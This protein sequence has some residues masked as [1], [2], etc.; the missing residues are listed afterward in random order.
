M[1]E[2]HKCADLAC[3][4]SQLNRVADSH[5]NEYVA[6]LNTPTPDYTSETDLPPP[7]LSRLG[8]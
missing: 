4:C 2:P 1:S 7:S 3:N 6:D 5:I 8:V